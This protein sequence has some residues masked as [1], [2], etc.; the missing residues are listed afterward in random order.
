[1][2]TRLR[3]I[4]LCSGLTVTMLCGAPRPAHAATPALIAT[5]GAIYEFIKEAYDFYKAA[6][7]ILEGSGPSIAEQLKAVED[8]II[9]EMRTQRNQALT[10]SMRAV[11]DESANFLD[12][13]VGDPTNPSMFTDILGRMY[14]ASANMS[15][16]VTPGNDANSSY[17]LAATYNSLIA[18]G[19]G[20]L[21]AKGQV[22]PDFPS[23]WGDF[24]HWLQAAMETDYQM[25]GSQRN[26]CFVYANKNPGYRPPPS[27]FS[28]PAGYATW[29]VTT[30]PGPYKNSQLWR[31]LTNR[32]IPVATYTCSNCGPRSTSCP[33]PSTAVMTCNPGTKT[34]IPGTS[35][36]CT[37]VS[38]QC[39]A[40]VA[41]LACAESLAKPGFD[42]D[43]VV[44]IIRQGMIGID[45]RS[46][47]WDAD[48][49][50][51][52]P[53]V[54]QGKLVDPYVAESSCPSGWAYPQQ[55]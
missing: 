9:G 11:F 27:L 19:T 52:D 36:A 22:F 44:Q 28:D 48:I 54:A 17:E 24:F 40:S 41:P 35:G 10:A 16:I 13:K 45:T 20:I 3:T 12:N 51:N 43:V 37:L 26:Q 53:L 2:K 14:E 6:M 30:L 5:A 34:C 18:V 29:L 32:N 38:R 42:A 23:S 55:P 47:G 39:D 21:E 31:K 15:E 50:S 8:A 49:A 7:E 1:M 25:I 33:P 46:G 4:I